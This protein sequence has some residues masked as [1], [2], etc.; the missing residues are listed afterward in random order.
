[1]G[2]KTYLYQIN[3]LYAVLFNS[4][5]AVIKI[6]VRKQSSLYHYQEPESWPSKQRLKTGNTKPSYELS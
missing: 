4:V 5:S 6:W 3:W 2:L 1:M